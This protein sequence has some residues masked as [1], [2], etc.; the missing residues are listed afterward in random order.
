MAQVDPVMLRQLPRIEKIIQDEMWYEGERRGCAVTRD[1]PV[2]RERVCR[3]ILQIGA[4]MRAE[5]TA[6][7]RRPP[8]APRVLPSGQEP[9]GRAA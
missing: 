8:A 9:A 2:V 6:D 1:D 7:L 4:Q 5:L 3:I